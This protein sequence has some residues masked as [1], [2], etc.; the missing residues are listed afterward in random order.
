MFQAWLVLTNDRAPINPL[1]VA[2]LYRWLLDFEHRANR[3]ERGVIY[4]QSDRWR[5]VREDVRTMFLMFSH[6]QPALAAQYLRD[7]RAEGARYHDLKSLIK[8]PGSLPTAAPAEFV[9]LLLSELIPVEDPDDFSSRRG[10][11][12]SPFDVHDHDFSPVSPGQGP[13][14]ALLQS[15]PQEGLRLI[16]SLVEYAATWRAEHVS[17]QGAAIPTIT[18]PFPDSDRTYVGDFG[19]YQW[20]RGGTRSMTVASA[21]MALEV[22][23]TNKLRP[24]S[25]SKR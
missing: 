7:L 4:I 21:L 24:G 22:W 12:L 5:E 23:G 11:A 1:I 20:A 9:D 8:T 10:Y 6:L 18:I 15:A 2:C 13:F 19:A 14:F 17:N 3:R 25:H 16:R